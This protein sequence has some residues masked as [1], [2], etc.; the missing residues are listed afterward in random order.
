MKLA[1]NAPTSPIPADVLEA[2]AALP[3]ARRDALVAWLRGALARMNRPPRPP[4]PVTTRPAVRDITPRDEPEG[5][6]LTPV[7]SAWL[8]RVDVPD[9]TSGG[10]AA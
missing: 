10:N 4:R 3:E 9:D 2:I 1:T 8:G 5:H 6:G 7:L